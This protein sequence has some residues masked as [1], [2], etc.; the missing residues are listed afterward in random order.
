MK[1]T[2]PLRIILTVVISLTL[3]SCIDDDDFIT[4]GQDIGFITT[5]NGIKCAATS[6]GYVT[7]PEIKSLSL[8]ECYILGYRITNLPVN[9]IYTADQVYHV[10]EKP[11]PQTALQIRKPTDSSSVA[12]QDLNILFYA[13]TNYMGDRWMFTYSALA[14]SDENISAHFFYDKDNQMD[15]SGNNIKGKNKLIIDVY[16]TKTSPAGSNTEVKERTFSAVGNLEGLRAF[17]FTPEYS[18][19]VSTN[20]YGKMYMAVQIQFRY[21]KYIAANTFETAY[22]GSWNGENDHR[23]YDLI[24]Y[25]YTNKIQ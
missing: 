17:A 20:Q 9:G 10:S 16:F 5:E 24:E 23:V 25:Y 6:Y 14:K 21:H 15:K 3:F 2:T 19:E 4:C 12:V 1:K 13:H 7:S 18:Q 11:I 8:N 22:L